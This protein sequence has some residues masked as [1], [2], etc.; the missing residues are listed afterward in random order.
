MIAGRDYTDEPEIPDPKKDNISPTETID[1]IVKLAAADITEDDLKPD[2]P[3]EPVSVPNL[4][5]I[6]NKTTTPINT[7]VSVAMPNSTPTNT[8]TLLKRVKQTPRTTPSILN[9][10]ITN[11]NILQ[12]T[13]T[14]PVV[15]PKARPPLKVFSQSATRPK[16]TTLVRSV[17]QSKPRPRSNILPKPK[18]N[19]AGCVNSHPTPKIPQAKPVTSL[20]NVPKKIGNTTVYR[21]VLHF[22]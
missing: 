10:A 3:S 19:I 12:K 1:N 6:T 21:C 4:V 7:P 17:Q 20:N 5:P 16:T 14:S 2:K 15:T 22:L 18:F 8:V 11:S 13:L 9:T